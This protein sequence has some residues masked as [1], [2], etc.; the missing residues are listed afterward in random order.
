MWEAQSPPGGARTRG[1]VTS[2]AAGL[3]AG[4]VAGDV[5]ALA[6]IRSRRGAEAVAL[7]ARGRVPAS[8]GEIAA[9]RSGYLADDRRALE[10]GLRD[11]GITGMAA[12]TALEVGVNI[13][14]LDA[15]LIA[16][17]P[18]TWASL[19][20]Q[21][22]RAGRSGRAA[23]AVFIARDDP[24]D[25]YLVRHPD[26]LLP[27]SVEP[28]VLDPVNPYVLAPHLA[29]A[30][31]EL[32]LTESDLALFSGAGHS[33]AEDSAAEDGA[34]EDRAPEDRAAEATAGV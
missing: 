20:Q 18:G 10:D 9:Y 12:T 5:P 19:W 27:R 1:P 23:T 25:T 11:G 33:A 32:P 24:L 28:T 22:R 15:V 16:G 2:E 4:L 26:A 14:A 8:V 29:S 6:F 17:W 21:A 3:L 13:P 30:A 34:A 31:A 7:S